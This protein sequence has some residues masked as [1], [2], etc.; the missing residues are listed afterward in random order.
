MRKLI[1]VCHYL[2]KLG[3]VAGSEGNISIRRENEIYIKASGVY[4]AEAKEGDFVK[5]DL[6]G[7]WEGKKRPSIELPMHLAIYK[8]RKEVNAII[9]S[10]PPYTTA[11]SVLDIP[12]ELI[13]EEARMYLS[14]GVRVI[15]YREPGSQALAKDVENAVKRGVNLLILR[16]HGV[17]ALGGSIEEALERTIAIERCAHVLY[18]VNLLKRRVLFK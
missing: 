12:I 2:D 10:H 18:L 1:W 11:L 7:K 16:G 15:G 5:V 13:T 14:D 6:S 17:V 8:V 4:L 9:H 3:Y